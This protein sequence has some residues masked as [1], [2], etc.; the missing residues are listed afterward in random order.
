M[1]QS[2]CL[3][4]EDIKKTLPKLS[5][6]EIIEIDKLLHDYIETS[7][8]MGASE[9]AFAEWDDPEEDIYNEDV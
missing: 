7:M 5:K 9:L 4:M 1:T 2:S 3:T 8:M 6:N